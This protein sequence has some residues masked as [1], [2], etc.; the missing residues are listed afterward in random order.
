ML[1][2][3]Y[4][5]AHLIFTRIEKW[6]TEYKGQN[7]IQH[8]YLQ[9]DNASV[10]LT[11]NN[12]KELTTH[13]VIL[14]HLQFSLIPQ[15]AHS[16]DL[17]ICNLRLFKSLQAHLL[18]ENITNIDKLIATLQQTYNAMDPS[19]INHIFIKV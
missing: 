19:T 18:K 2:T 5:R 8:I 15:P 4:I 12:S 14:L 13:L 9:Q 17:N 7:T 1:F 6:P 10:H 11:Q 16:T 3:N